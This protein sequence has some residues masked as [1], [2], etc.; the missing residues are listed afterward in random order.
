M[1]TAN[2]N[3]RFLLR[4]WI[5]TLALCLIAGSF[6]V[7][8]L[9]SG[10]LEQYSP[11]AAALL[12]A[13]VLIVSIRWYKKR[14]L[15]RALQSP[16]PTEYLRSTAKSLRRLPH[17]SQIAV[18]TSTTFLALYGRFA[19]AERSLASVTW[20]D[21]PPLIEAQAAIARAAIAYA[22]GDLDA[23]LE[24]TETAVK[25]GSVDSRFP[26]AKTSDLAFRT[27][28]NLGLA[29]SGK[30]SEGTVQELRDARLRLPLLGQIN[31]AWGLAVIAKRNGSPAEHEKLVQFI[32]S[33]AP[34]S[35]PVLQSIQ[36]A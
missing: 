18:A 32:K 28:F 4:R 20:S 26:G 10:N 24:F 9:T 36:A 8:G 35:T 12:F 1:S 15:A 11:T 2:N 16:D 17:G 27:W 23:G 19:E 21:L 13:I 31:A 6:L 30:S 7:A 33:T 22:K 29:L 25:Q 5:P 3:R 34:H 14:Q